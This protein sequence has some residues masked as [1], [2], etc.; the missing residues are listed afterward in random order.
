MTESRELSASRILDR[1]LID[2][3]VG[4]RSLE[5]LDTLNARVQIA[6]PIYHGMRRMAHSHTLL[7]L[8]KFSEFYDEFHDLIPN[9]CR[10]PC[11]NIKKLI[12]SKKIYEF[13]SKYVAHITDEKTGRPLNPDELE[14]YIQS[15]FGV[16]DSNFVRWVNDQVNEFPKTVVS[17]L[18]KTRDG[19]MAANN[20]SKEQ[21]E[22]GRINAG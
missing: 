8:C 11:K 20:I 2:V 4:T 10:T 22:F 3:I 13:R 18:E 6:A 16:D 7:G 9:E 12:K 21:M 14:N 5:I 19:I 15:I 1:L 17:V